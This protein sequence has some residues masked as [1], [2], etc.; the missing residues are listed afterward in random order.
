MIKSFDYNAANGNF[1]PNARSTTFADLS[2]QV[3]NYW[4]RGLTGIAVDPDFGTAGHNFIYV[5]YAYNHDPRTTRAGRAAVGRPGPAVRRL[6]RT[7]PPGQATAITGCLVMV[8]VTRL[9]AQRCRHDGW[10]M[11][12]GSEKQL[13]PAAAS[14]SA[15]T[16]RATSSSVRTACSTPRQATVRASTASTTASTTTPAPTRPTRV[17]R[18]RSQ[19]YRSTGDPLG[20][21]GSIVRMDPGQR[22]NPSQGTAAQWLVAYGQ[23]NP[24]RL[25]SGRAPSSSGRATSAAALGRRSTGSPTCAR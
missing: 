17:A 12:A 6:P 10:T 25:R 7:R 4:D 1:E 9:T 5:N 18:C 19:D 8:R 24:W 14:S 13:L 3:N 22:F 11:S 15:A 16:P 21:D 2:R 23:R 20:L